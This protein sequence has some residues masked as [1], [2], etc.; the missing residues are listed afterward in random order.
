MFGGA[1]GSVF[2]NIYLRKT[3]QYKRILSANGIISVIGILSF[4]ALLYTK[5][6]WIVSIG[7]FLC[8][9]SICPFFPISLEYG[10]E[11]LFP[12]GEGSAA[13]FLLASIHLFGFGQVM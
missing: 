13:G 4:L 7:T 2:W 5:N 8:G 3:Q 6:E 11:L 9:F 10:C 12:I 1:S